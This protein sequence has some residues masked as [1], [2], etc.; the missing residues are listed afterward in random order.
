MALSI[1]YVD[2]GHLLSLRLAFYREKE[3]YYLPVILVYSFI[4]AFSLLIDDLLSISFVCSIIPREYSSTY[5]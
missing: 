2:P 3:Y 1:Y 5:Y 4:G